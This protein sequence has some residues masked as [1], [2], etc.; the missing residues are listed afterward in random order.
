MWM[1]NLKFKCC[2][3]SNECALFSYRSKTQMAGHEVQT[4]FAAFSQRC[5]MWVVIVIEIHLGF[6]V[7]ICDGRL[8]CYWDS[9][10][11]FLKLC[12]EQLIDS[13][14]NCGFKQDQISWKYVENWFI[15]SFLWNEASQNLSWF[16]YFLI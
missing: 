15:G 5:M 3:V 1:L 8:I 7:K 6:F 11:F 9:F 13:F 10:W 4:F 2:M 16:R 12:G 14:L